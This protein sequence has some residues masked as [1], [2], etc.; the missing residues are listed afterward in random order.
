MLNIFLL[1]FFLANNS[2]SQNT[3]VYI[4]IEKNIEEEKIILYNFKSQTTAQIN[5]NAT[6]DIKEI[7]RTDLMLSR[8]FKVIE[9]ED[10]KEISNELPDFFSTLSKFVVTANINISENNLQLNGILYETKSRNKIFEKIYSSE[11][12]GLRK[13][14]HMFSDD[15]VEKTIKRKGIAT[16]R[17]VFSNDSTG[18]KE[19]YM[20][21]YDGE[22]LFQL[23]NHRSISIVPKWSNDSNRIYYTS[24][25]Y[26]NPDLFIID[27]IEG[28]IRAFSKYQGLNIAGGFSPDGSQMVLTLSRGKDPSIY[29]ANLVSKDIKKLLDNFGVCSSPTFSPDGKEIAF[30]SDRAGNPQ[31]YIY[32]LE[33]KKYRKLTNF[34]WVDSP[35]WS[36]DGMW[37]VFSG[38]S[39][40]KENLN[41][42][43]MD[44]TT[45]VIKRL[46]RNEGNNE[47][48]SFSPDSR[49]IAFTSTR[50]KKRQIFIMDRDGS[51]PRL[52]SEKIKGNSYTPI[53]SR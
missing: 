16:S 44:P 15:I 50:N 4:G 35:N 9:I 20:I 53:W 42:F 8:Y 5:I 26:G 34:N 40:S 36:V 1:T 33:T 3:E 32:N 14:A 11:L 30:I 22:N 19:I 21:D 27:L 18:Y 12:E 6:S 37:I 52:L 38:R 39:T 10:D 29:I 25:R 31:L 45:S 43:I 2:F 7:V 48:P 17:L 28:K 41:I 49:F 46:T 51:S 13:I 24:Y 23:T 47:D